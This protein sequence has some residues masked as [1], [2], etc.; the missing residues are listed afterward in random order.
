MKQSAE[1]IYK[2]ENLRALR[3]KYGFS[4]REFIDEF[5]TED[6]VKAVSI[7]TLSNL[8]AKG[9]KRLDEI[10]QKVSQKLGTDVIAFEMKPERFVQ[11]MDDMFPDEVNSLEE[12]EDNDSKKINSSQL[13]NLITMYFADQMLD[14]KLKKGDKIESDRNLA[15]KFN[16]G[17]S[18]IREA[19]KILSVMGMIEIRP[20]QGSFI[21]NKESNFFTIPLAWSFFLNSSQIDQ[22]VV[23]RNMLE[24]QAAELAAVTRD[25]DKLATL[26]VIFQDMYKACNALDSKAFL[27]SDREF[28]HAVAEASGNQI[29]MTLLGTIENLMNRISGSGM[30]EVGGL[31]TIFDEHKEIY[32]HIL[33]HDPKGAKESME[34]HLKNSQLRYD[35]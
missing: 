35:Y 26:D 17:R 18:A 33:T 21:S 9:G 19:L 4:Q 7:A 14:G 27:Q 8:E 15:L 23:L 22:I 34:Y 28:H 3:R 11:R 30:L 32:G 12:V 24:I 29:I 1:D 16:V 13:I 2:R 20:G 31:K 5:L 6:G 10:L 25:T